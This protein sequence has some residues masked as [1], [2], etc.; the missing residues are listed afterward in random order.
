MIHWLNWIMLRIILSCLTHH[1]SPV[2]CCIVLV[3]ENVLLNFQPNLTKKT[4]Q[5]CYA[6]SKTENGIFFFFCEYNMC[7]YKAASN[8][9]YFLSSGISKLLGYKWRGKK[10]YNGHLKVT[11]LRRFLIWRRRGKESLL[12]LFKQHVSMECLCIISCSTKA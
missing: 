2:T 4:D 1:S 12:L 5:V 7:I 10:N 11:N 8:L 9:L 6:A 3:F